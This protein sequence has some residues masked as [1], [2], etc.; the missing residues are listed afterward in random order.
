MQGDVKAVT[1]QGNQIKGQLSNGQSFTT[2]T[3]EDPQLVQ[4]MLDHNVSIKVQPDR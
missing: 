3:P 2:Y 1:I 4:R